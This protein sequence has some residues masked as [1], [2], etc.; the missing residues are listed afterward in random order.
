MGHPYK[1][2]KH[3]ATILFQNAD[4]RQNLA[5]EKQQFVRALTHF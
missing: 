5:G 4:S 3:V 1:I 2:A